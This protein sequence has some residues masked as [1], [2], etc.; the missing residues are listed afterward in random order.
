MQVRERTAEWQTPVIVWMSGRLLSRPTRLQ[1]TGSQKEGRKEGADRARVE[2]SRR[3]LGN[4]A[5]SN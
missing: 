5:G 4:H 1:V 3:V 2:G